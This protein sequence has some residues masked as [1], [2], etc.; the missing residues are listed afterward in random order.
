[1]PRPPIPLN[2]LLCLDLYAT[3][4]AVI[5]AYRPLLDALGLTYPQYLVMVALWEAGP[6]GVKE[7]SERL[8]LDSGTLSPLLKRLEA[9]KLV[10][11]TRDSDDERAVTIALTE[12]GRAL[13]EKSYAVGEGIACLFA[14]KP[15]EARTLQTMLREISQRMDAAG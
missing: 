11:R 7:L 5:K 13:Q 8:S 10:T 1:M 9:M 6:L 3:S 15:E 4:R 12:S 14:L 2:A